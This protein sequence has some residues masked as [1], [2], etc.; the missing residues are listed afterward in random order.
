MSA[1]SRAPGRPSFVTVGEMISAS[2][3]G[4]T[5][6]EYLREEDLRLSKRMEYISFAQSS[7]YYCSGIL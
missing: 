3:F 5:D 6:M 1:I 4:V 7:D 2:I